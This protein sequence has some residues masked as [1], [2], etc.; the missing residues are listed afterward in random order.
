M[1]ALRSAA[2]LGARVRYWRTGTDHP[3]CLVL[4]HGLGADHRGLAEMAGMIRGYDIVALDLPGF[5]RSEPLPRRYTME[6]YSDAVEELRVHLG[7]ERLHLTGHSMGANIAL[8][9]AARYGASLQSLCLLNPVW[10]VEGAATALARVYYEIGARLPRPLD[11]LW[12]ASRAAVYIGD[13]LTFTIKDRARRRRILDRDYVNMRRAD[14]RAIKQ[15]YLSYLDTPWEAYA[16]R[17]TARTLIVT[18]SRDLVARP[19]TV[20]RLQE[21][22]SGSVSMVLQDAGHLL[23]TELPVRVGALV[24]RFLAGTPVR[25]TVGRQA[26]GSRHRAPTTRTVEATP[27][28]GRPPVS[29]GS[30]ARSPSSSYR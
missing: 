25:R 21:G 26:A 16:A 8:V 5:G 14:L 23:P 1:A 18:G 12:L 13:M 7:R 2:V 3:E 19:S 10:Q 22:I 24:N 17:I 6:A 30:P 27:G 20:R 29:T 9:Y 28:R 11:R 15:S 4:L